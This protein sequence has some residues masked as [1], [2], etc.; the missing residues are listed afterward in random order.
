MKVPL[1]LLLTLLA[2]SARS[3][4][5]YYW[6]PVAKPAGSMWGGEKLP[7]SKLLSLAHWKSSLWIA[8]DSGI[9]SSDEEGKKWTRELSPATPLAKAHLAGNSKHLFAATPVGVFRRE[10][11]GTWTA[12]DKG[13]GLE[14]PFYILAS[15]SQ[16][17][18]GMQ[19]SRLY[20]F[21]PSD[22]A[23]HFVPPLSS[24]SI[25]LAALRGHTLFTDQDYN[26]RSEDAGAAWTRFDDGCSIASMASNGD[27]A[28]VFES[29]EAGKKSFRVFGSE[30]GDSSRQTA[31]FLPTRTF[32]RHG[33]QIDGSTIV[34]YSGQFHLSRD[35]GAT[36]DSTS[37][38]SPVNYPKDFV[39]IA[40]LP[41]K[42]LLGTTDGIWMVHV[43]TSGARP[44]R[45]GAVAPGNRKATYRRMGGKLAVMTEEKSLRAMDGRRV[46]VQGP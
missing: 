46:R 7:G 19:S 27:Y 13:L 16:L 21:N 32:F 45:P 6:I 40:S 37:G 4:P 8:T 33:L 38:A 2:V 10:E 15:D 42:I 44:T 26:F 23:W 22:T 5:Q 35:R 25:S 30:G 3:Q 11:A 34:A 31:E 43:Q 29:C 17:F 18:C 36:W 28:I 39:G 24:G 14:K 1:A 12:L 9:F 41:G 20:F